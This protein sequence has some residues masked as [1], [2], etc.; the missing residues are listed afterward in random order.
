MKNWILIL[1]L[2]LPLL[3][4]SQIPNPGFED[5]NPG[6][7]P[8][9]W[10]INS[11]PWTL[12]PWDPY[13][14]RQDSGLNAHQGRYAMNLHSNGFFKAVTSARF[15]LNGRPDSLIFWYKLHFPPCVNDP[16]YPQQDTVSAEVRFLYRGQVLQQMKWEALES[17]LSYTRQALA[18]PALSS[19][20]DSCEI[21]FEGGKVY[22]GCGFA[23]ASTEFWIDALSWHGLSPLS[24]IDSSV[25]D[26]SSACLTVFDPVCGCDSITYSNSCEAYYHH[27]ITSWIPGPCSF[28][29]PPSC[30]DTALICI[31]CPCPTVIDPVCGCDSVTYQNSCFAQNAGLSSWTAGACVPQNFCDATFIYS[32]SRDTVWF[33]SQASGSIILSQL[34]TFGDGDSS[35]L[36]NPVHVY[37]ATGNYRVC[38]FVEA[39]GPQGQY[40]IDSSCMSIYVTADCIDTSLICEPP[41]LCC[42]APLYDPV[43]GCDGETYD[44]ACIAALLF[45]VSSSSPGPCSSS[46][47]ANLNAEGMSIYPNPAGREL[48][49]ELTESVQ[50]VE[51]FNVLGEKMLLTVEHTESSRRVRL[52]VESVPAGIYL[53]RAETVNG[54]FAESRL[55]KH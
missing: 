7:V 8:D 54:K 14:I 52:N 42:D 53:L 17:Q 31:G 20:A 51:L 9:R 13:I 30:I 39:L 37:A 23:A 12:P 26:L 15:P 55:I 18:M 22:G 49:L 44:N 32:R 50:R 11:H 1:V 28:N 4:H 29:P 45:G 34:W 41:G 5:W 24:C 16:G 6:P 2:Q 38:F 19:F 47:L 40:C 36:Q 46:S 43:C 48:Y 27:G 35:G 3:L 25:I 10:S 21:R 33:S